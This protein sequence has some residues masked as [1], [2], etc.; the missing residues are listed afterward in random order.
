MLSGGGDLGDLSHLLPGL[1]LPGGKY[2]LSTRRARSV[3]FISRSCSRTPLWPPSAWFRWLVSRS[4]VQF[5]TISPSTP[6]I[7]Q[8]TFPI[9][10]YVSITGVIIY[11]LLYHLPRREPGQAPVTL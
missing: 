11:L 9:W 7:A 3:G 2:A 8:V 4:S 6:A 1:S 5:G 10:V